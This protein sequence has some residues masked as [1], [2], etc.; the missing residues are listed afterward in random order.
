MDAVEVPSTLLAVE[1]LF[2]NVREMSRISNTSA[3]SPAVPPTAVLVSGCT[4]IVCS[5]AACE[6][7]SRN[8]IDI[9][10]KYICG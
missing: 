3:R 9:C 5:I 2:G 6:R 10:H 8:F 1:L 7:T 4:F